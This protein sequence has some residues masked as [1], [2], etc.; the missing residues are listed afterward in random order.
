VSEETWG[1]MAQ[2]KELSGV[3]LPGVF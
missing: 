2:L 1:M 3:S